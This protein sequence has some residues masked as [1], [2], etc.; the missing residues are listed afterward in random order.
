MKEY[1]KLFNDL[2]SADGYIIEDIPFTTTVK[3][4]AESLAP[5]NVRC[6][7]DSMGLKVEN[8]TVKVIKLAP[9]NTILHLKNSTDVE[10][11][12]TTITSAMTK[13]L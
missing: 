6:N 13:K 12:A 9:L 4:D 1:I 11:T 10:L 5:Q 2:E 3:R 7:V 8:D